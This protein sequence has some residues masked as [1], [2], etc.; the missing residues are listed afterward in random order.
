MGPPPA[1]VG[2]TPDLLDVQVD[3][4]ARVAGHDPFRTPVGRA[5]RVEEAALVDA[6]ARQP[7]A[8]GA[9]ADPHA[10]ARE[11]KGDPAGGPLVVPP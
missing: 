1:A 9:L 5:I 7:P 8:Y 2:D 4:V 11:F 3:H 10:L 6:Q